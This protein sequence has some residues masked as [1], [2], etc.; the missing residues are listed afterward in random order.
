MPLISTSVR[1][2]LLLIYVPVQRLT[3]I[4]THFPRSIAL[5][6]A[7][8]SRKQW[9]SSSSASPRT[10]T[11]NHYPTTAVR[12][13]TMIAELVYQTVNSWC[14]M[15]CCEVLHN[16]MSR[17]T[18]ILRQFR[19]KLLIPHCPSVCLHVSPVAMVCI[20]EIDA[21]PLVPNSET[22]LHLY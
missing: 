11:L 21:Y 10:P 8:Q 20:L 4:S 13:C 7:F 15:L 22:A 5:F 2:R 1:F 14:S 17:S 19:L 3:R 12:S 6:Y 16:R 9:G 18:V